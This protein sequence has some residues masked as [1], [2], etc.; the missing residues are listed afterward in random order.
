M[1]VELMNQGLSY[2]DLFDIEIEQKNAKKN[3]TAQEYF[4]SLLH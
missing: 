2:H 4:M 1:T 3:Q